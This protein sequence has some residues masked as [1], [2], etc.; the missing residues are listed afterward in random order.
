MFK[1]KIVITTTLLIFF[2]VITSTIKNKTRILEKNI[3]NL[4]NE[5]ALKEKNLNETQLDFY[6]LT[7]P[8]EIEK[9]I[10]IISYKDYQP[11]VHSK[12]FLSINELITIKSQQSNLKNSNEKKIKKKFK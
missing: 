1:T 5:I 11:I 8:A 4:N 3:I 7:S 12:I 6:Y 2:L 9:R 10:E